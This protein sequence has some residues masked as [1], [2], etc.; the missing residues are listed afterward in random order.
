MCCKEKNIF[1]RR[2]MICRR[3]VVSEH[4]PFVFEMFFSLLFHDTTSNAQM[5]Q[6][7]RPLQIFLAKAEMPRQMQL[8]LFKNTSMQLKTLKILFLFTCWQITNT[9]QKLTSWNLLLFDD[10]RKYF[11]LVFITVPGNY[12]E[13]TSLWRLRHTPPG[14]FGKGSAHWNLADIRR[15]G[16]LRDNLV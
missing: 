11:F 12:R 5:K 4:E 8:L 10:S 13:R 14:L 2:P 16:S 15:T 6:K 7:A 3:G 1:F 9:R